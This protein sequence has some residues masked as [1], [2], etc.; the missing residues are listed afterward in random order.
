MEA[1]N[2]AI[3]GTGISGLACAHFLHSRHTVTLFEKDAR[4]GGHSHTVTIP[5]GD[6]EVALDTGFMVYNEVTYPLLT[7]LF[8]DLGVETKPTSMSF[9]VQHVRERFEF[10]GS[11]FNKI[12][13]QR[14]NVFSPRFWKMLFQIKRFNE[15]TIAELADPQYPDCTLADYVK[16][17]GYG[18]DFLKWYLSPMAAAVWS[19]PP[20]R[21]SAFPAH[22]LMRFWHNHGFLG[23]KTHHPWRTVVGGS[24][25]YVEKVSAPFAERI[26]KGKGVQSVNGRQ[27]TFADGTTEEFDLVI[28][29][30]HGDQSY[31][32][33]KDA[34]EEEERLLSCFQY[35]DNVA[36]VH[37]DPK[38]MPRI[39]RCWASW[40]Y[41][42]DGEKHSTHYWMN[43]L[44]GVSEQEDY[45]VSI[46]PPG[47]VEEAFVKRRL[48]YEH[49]IFD[50]KAIAAQDELAALNEAGR[51]TGR[52]YCGAWQ[53]YGFHEDGI[54]SA[55]RL[56][57]QLLEGDPWP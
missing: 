42:V 56:C 46:N 21:I 8:R 38:F 10:N 34:S 23:L 20:E 48:N 54:W 51:N 13:G 16:Q 39:K 6:E 18:E 17:R 32:L 2:I 35:Q 45:F 47:E 28:F 9:S 44:Q 53:R 50:L 3:I 25:R 40:N 7:R 24:R 41:R 1:K 57:E 33:L 55:H 4:V 22:T 5:E 49:P 29:A 12:F 52:Y 26:K 11:G 31:R 37:S 27:L 19:S 30:S 36:L 14:K 15:E 43:S